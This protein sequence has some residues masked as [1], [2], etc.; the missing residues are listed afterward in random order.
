MHWVYPLAAVLAI[1]GAVYCL[2]VALVFTV[3]ERHKEEDDD[4]W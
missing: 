1:L 4:E 3:M 2:G